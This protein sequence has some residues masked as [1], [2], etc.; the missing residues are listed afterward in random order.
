MK[1]E[2]EQLKKEFNERIDKLKKKYEEP[3]KFEVGKWYIHKIYRQLIFNYQPGESYGMGA[4]GWTTNYVHANDFN[5]HQPATE[6]EVK[7]MLINEAKKRGFKE[8]VTVVRS[9]ELLKHED[10]EI[11]SDE[12]MDI[13]SNTFEYNLETDSLNIDGRY[14]YSHGQ[15]ATII[16]Q[17]PLTIGGYEVVIHPRAEEISVNGVTYSKE[18][19]L[20]AKKLFQTSVTSTLVALDLINKIL[21]RM[22]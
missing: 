6:S 12:P 18:F 7:E 5:T 2:L 15:W 8:G 16:K 19:L 10:C 21:D 14:I 13:D 4:N 9:A 22:K 3:A 1:T 11:L 20:Q 17:E